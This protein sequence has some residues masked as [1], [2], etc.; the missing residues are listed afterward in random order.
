MI[1]KNLSWKLF[2]YLLG[3]GSYFLFTIAAIRYLGPSGYGELAFALSWTGLFAILVDYGFNPI[4]TRD[5]PQNPQQGNV[6]FS[7]I[8]LLKGL[9]WMAA[10]FLLFV[11]SSRHPRAKVLLSLIGLT[12]LFQG[13]SSLAETGQSFTYAYERF[14]D[15]AWLSIT[16]KVLIA[17]LG[18]LAIAWGAG[19]TGIMASMACAG[20]AASVVMLLYFQRMFH[21]IPWFGVRKQTAVNLLVQGLPLLLQN[22]F[23]AVYFRIDT[24]MLSWMSGNRETGLYNAAYRFFELSNV[25]PTALLAISVAPLARNMQNREWKP[26]FRRSLAAFLGM[27]CLGVGVLELVAWGL[28]RY[29]LNETYSLSK[30]IL[31]ILSLTLIFLYPN[32]LL[33]TML[34]LLKKPA[35]NAWIAAFCVVFNITANLYA[36]PRWGGFGAAWTTLATEAVISV[37]SLALIYRYSL[38]ESAQPLP[39]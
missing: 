17:L 34:T 27:A 7:H 39:V 1:S 38:I 8:V 3:G 15:G 25:L 29:F 20:L 4:A 13:T 37:C 28:P 18:G 16:Q 22:V 36:I 14:R 19:V 9:L 12:M 33:T 10:V 23:I 21:G 30:P 6:Y 24:V 35:A 32:Y 11:I 2:G 5:L 26:L 31:Q